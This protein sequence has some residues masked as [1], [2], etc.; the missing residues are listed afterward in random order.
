MLQG[1]VR[2]EVLIGVCGL[3]IDRNF[4]LPSL[5][6]ID[7]GMAACCQVPVLW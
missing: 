6:Y 2:R 1:V 7:P 3:P 4:S 5:E